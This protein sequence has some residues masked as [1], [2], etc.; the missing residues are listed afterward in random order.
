MPR[1]CTNCGKELADGEI[2][3]PNCGTKM[4]TVITPGGYN[5]TVQ[6]PLLGNSDKMKAIKNIGIALIV[7]G[8]VG[9]FFGNIMF[10]D[11]GIAAGFAGVVSLVTG[12]GF[13]KLA[14]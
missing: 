5:T 12:Y 11:I 7:L 4:E 2:F 14:Q 13:I 6:Q 1:I 8:V 3:C 9:L 10:G